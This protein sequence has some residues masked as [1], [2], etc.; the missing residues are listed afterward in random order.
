[1][2]KSGVHGN[3]FTFPLVLKACAKLG[4]I[5]DG[6]KIHTHVFL[7]GFQGDVFVQTALID[8]YSKCSNLSS[9]RHLFDEM[10]IRS[11]VSWNSMISAYCKDFQIDE[12]FGLLK[13]MRFLDLEPSSSTLVSIVSGCSGSGFGALWHGLS[14]HCYGIK[15]GLTS[16]LLLSNSI[17]SMYIQFDQIDAARALF[18][19]MAEKS[20]ISWTAIIGG[21][22]K[23]GDVGE[24]FNLFNQMRQ[25]QI[26]L[27]SIVFINLSSGCTQVGRVFVASSLHGLIVKSGCDCDEPVENSLVSMYSKCGDLVSA[28]KI[29]DLVHEKSTFLWTAM[30][31]GYTHFGYPNEALNLFKILLNTSSRPNEVTLAT[32]LSACADLG[33]LSLGREIEEYIRMNGLD[34]DLRVQTSL[35]HMYCKC[36]SIERAKEVF[37]R[38]CNRDLTMW[39]SMINGY[40]I[41]G[42]GEEALNLFV[43]MQRQEGIKP[44]SVVYTG[45]LSACSHSGF[46]EEGMK[47]FECMQRDGI[48][49]SVE[50]Y[51]CLVDL[52]G[53]AGYLKLALN[54]I[55]EM[56]EPVQAQAWVPLLSACRKHRDIEL[57]EFV[58]KR[59]FDLES[60]GT[61]NY[62]LMANMYISI[63]RWKD[64]ATMRRLMNDKGLVKEPGWSQI[65]VNG[66]I[67]VFL[68]GDQ[69]HHRSVEIYEKLDV[70]N[71]KLREAGYVAETEMAMHD[72]EKEEREEALRVHSERLAIAFGLLS[73]EPGTTLRII[74][75]LRTCNDCHSA[76]KFISKITSRHLIV[77]DGHR[78][79]HFESGSCSCRDFW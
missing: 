12:S 16:D 76:F 45:V 66:S 22:I 38:A 78:F 58:A 27:D 47:F 15:L 40:A 42:M 46:V 8:M 29:F 64:A 9:S 1:M 37:D 5:R 69:S 72:L 25:E 53:R 57:G 13:Q 2:L 31:S 63:G 61:S 26:S 34:S 39:S 54:T 24:A 70:L 28:R 43:K 62:I 56:P 44:D 6:T 35:V 7:M 17:M 52:L 73:T 49:P 41:H 65:E 18:Y 11:V 14:I 48:V 51:L 67:H 33:S 79:H 10:P 36:G 19:S 68:V 55:E 20:T 75:N 77:R 21:F 4:S 50:H 32:V 23:I 59:L 60:H 30:I 74:K 71:A 3:N